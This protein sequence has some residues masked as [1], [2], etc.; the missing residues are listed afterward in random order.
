[1]TTWRLITTTPT[2]RMLEEGRRGW[3]ARSTVEDGLARVYTRM[4][5][6]TPDP[7]QATTLEAQ[8]TQCIAQ[9]ANPEEA[10]HAVL[11]LL[12]FGKPRKRPDPRR[13]GRTAHHRVTYQGKD[14]T[15]RE[16]HR[17]AH[18]SVNYNTLRDRILQRH[19]DIQRALTTPPQR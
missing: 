16:L 18:P 7:R 12:T 3:N 1:M 17:F 4:T 10:A 6:A 13:P 9:S 2:S 19:W 5:R 8:I 11:E 15:L 14:Y